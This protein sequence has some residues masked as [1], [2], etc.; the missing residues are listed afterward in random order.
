MI[1][2]NQVYQYTDK[3]EKNRIRIIDIDNP[4]DITINDIASI[5]NEL[6]RFD[7]LKF[8]IEQKEIYVNDIHFVG[9]NPNYRREKIGETLYNKFFDVVQ[10]KVITTVR[11]VTSPVNKMSIK[12]HTHMGF[13]LEKGDSYVDGLPVFKNFDGDGQSRVLFYKNLK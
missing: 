5:E 7:F 10:S 4:Y 8:E 13:Q 1:F 12:F 11:A 3:E 9:V 2:Y 6:K